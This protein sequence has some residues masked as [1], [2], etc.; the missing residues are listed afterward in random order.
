M[1]LH[2]PKS[3]NFVRIFCS[4]V[5]VLRFYRRLTFFLTRRRPALGLAEV[6]GTLTQANPHEMHE[7]ERNAMRRTNTRNEP[8]IYRRSFVCAHP[9]TP[10]AGD[11]VLVANDL[12]GI[13]LS[14]ARNGAI[15]VDIGSSITRLTI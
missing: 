15:E 2:E 10:V 11:P 9:A 14:D 7:E 6:L 4:F 5:Q 13:A 12:A 1:P 8:P 3:N